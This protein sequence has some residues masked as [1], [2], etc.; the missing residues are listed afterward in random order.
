M[1]KLYCILTVGAGGFVGAALRYGAGLIFAQ[2]PFSH[3]KE[4][5]TL[6]VNALGS[7][8]IGASYALLQAKHPAWSLF[9]VVGVLG[10]FTTFSS[11]AYET[12]NLHSSGLFLKAALNVILNVS[13]CLLFVWAGAWASKLFN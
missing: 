8:I 13:V 9:I 3:G 11:F 2:I 12:F 1:G 5:S 4:L 10:G 6:F 7:F